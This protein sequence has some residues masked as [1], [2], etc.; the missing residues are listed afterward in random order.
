[1]T[2]NNAIVGAGIAVQSQWY[3]A[4]WDS[5]SNSMSS[6]YGL[7]QAK[8]VELNGR[9]PTDPSVAVAVMS[10]RIEDSVGSCIRKKLCQNETDNYLVAAMAQNGNSPNGWLHGPSLP[11][12]LDGSVDWD[13]VMTLGDH[14]GNPIAKARQKMKNMPY[15]T[16]FMLQLFTNDVKALQKSGFS[17]PDKY[18]D[19]DWR[20]IERLLNKGT[21]KHNDIK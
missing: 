11:T 8:S 19:V 18:D 9:D 21:V 2:D 4:A 5:P 1:V 17:L 3:L 14:T 12:S 13:E 7:A 20:T 6:S 10:E 15:N 16:Q